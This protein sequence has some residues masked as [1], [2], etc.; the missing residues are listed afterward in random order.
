M[1][2]IS[3]ELQFG[4]IALLIGVLI[5]ILAYRLLGRST[6]ESDKIV[7]E[8]DAAKAELNEY[9]ASVNLHFHK[10]SELVNELTQD[11]V[12]VYQ[13]LADGAQSLGDHESFN[14]L[15]EHQ[16][17]KVAI[18]LDDSTPATTEP[19]EPPVEPAQATA[20]APEE[21]IDEHAEPFIGPSTADAS[22]GKASD[23]KTDE[24][25]MAESSEQPAE[26]QV[27]ASPTD[28]KA[29]DTSAATE[30]P[31]ESKAAVLNVDALEEAIDKGDREDIPKVATA[32]TGGEEKAGTRPTTH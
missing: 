2:F 19:V 31:A 30:Q 32:P 7:E 21:A 15:L 24:P 5:G 29:E 6:R 22:E 17:G 14:N 25:L 27:T 13:H 18:T 12:K 4:A 10:T 16:K 11:Y 26:K 3:S 9:K 23:E 28:A 20:T 1:E 8:L